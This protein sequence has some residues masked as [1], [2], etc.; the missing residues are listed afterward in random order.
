[1]FSTVQLPK[2]FS[3]ITRHPLISSANN[4]NKTT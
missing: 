4:R 3:T 2:S 1:M